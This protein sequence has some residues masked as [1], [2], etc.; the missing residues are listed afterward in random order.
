MKAVLLGAGPLT[1]MTADI[2]IRRGAD[3]VIIEEDRETIEALQDH[4][5]CAF[6][7][8]DGSR[9]Q[10]LREA[11]PSPDAILFCL[12]DNDQSNILASLVGRSLGFGRVFTKI[13]DSDFEHICLELSLEDTIV[14][15]RHVAQILSGIAEGASPADFSAFFKNG[16]RL[17]SFIAGEEEE[18]PADEFDLPGQSKVVCIY[19]SDEAFVR[20]MEIKAGDE[21]VVLVNE[22]RMPELERRW[23][24]KRPSVASEF[25]AGLSPDQNKTE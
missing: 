24:D 17:F 19:R 3:V 15:D 6:I 23:R 4:L 8:G 14:P 25:E 7:H 9:P 11:G 2:L 16:L 5:D 12:S 10:I 1:R 20:N 18:G 13:E 22:D 21:V